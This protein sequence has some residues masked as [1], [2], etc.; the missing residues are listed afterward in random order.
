MIRKAIAL[1]ALLALV[2]CSNPSAI[3]VNDCTREG[4][5]GGT[6]EC[7]ADQTNL[8]TKAFDNGRM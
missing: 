6:G 5:I 7:T 4:G 3:L 2:A 1:I 8:S